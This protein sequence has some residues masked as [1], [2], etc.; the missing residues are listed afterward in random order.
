MLTPRQNKADTISTPVYG[1]ER[2]VLVPHEIGRAGPVSI[3]GVP[4]METLPRE[5][6]GQMSL[7]TGYGILAD[8]N[9]YKVGMVSIAWDSERNIPLMPVIGSPPTGVPSV[10][11]APRWVELLSIIWPWGQLAMRAC[12]IGFAEMRRTDERW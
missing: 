3:Q 8:L 4:R 11:V 7:P 2:T 10:E 12:V 9:L 1:P 5:A 6:V